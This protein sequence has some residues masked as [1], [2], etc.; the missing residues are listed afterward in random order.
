MINVTIDADMTNTPQ[1][2]EQMR[3]IIAELKKAH[4]DAFMNA[5][6]RGHGLKA[7]PLA[8]LIMQGNLT[9][10]YLM[11]EFPKIAKKESRLPRAYRD[12]IGSIV[13][14]AAQRTVIMRQA[15]RAE[16]IKEKANAR[17]AAEKANT[18]E[19]NEV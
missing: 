13:Y 5:Q 8:N 1:F 10:E 9:Y 2:K 4:K 17:A 12:V 18:I 16:K 6:D 3:G 7:S 11:D 14:N 19:A 15:E